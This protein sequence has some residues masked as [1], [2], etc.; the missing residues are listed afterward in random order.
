MGT[1]Y[2][3]PS[4]GLSHHH[5]NTGWEIVQRI[6]TAGANPPTVCHVGQQSLNNFKPPPPGNVL[7]SQSST[8]AQKHTCTVKWGRI[9]I[10]ELSSLFR[11]LMLNFLLIHQFLFCCLQAKFFPNCWTVF[12]KLR[13]F[14]LFPER[15]RWN[16]I[17]KY[18]YLYSQ[19]TIF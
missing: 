8:C 5:R 1:L 3:K 6:N 7:I 10:E 4:A 18:Y 9:Y 12:P 16:F 11:L 17:M 15:C 14:T 13:S 19:F 2:L